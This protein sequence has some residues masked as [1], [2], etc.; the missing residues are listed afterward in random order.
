MIIFILFMLPIVLL[1][2]LLLAGV[3]DDMLLGWALSD[4]LK[5]WTKHW[6]DERKPKE[7]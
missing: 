1:L 5:A 7:N 3:V 2:T 4:Y 6:L